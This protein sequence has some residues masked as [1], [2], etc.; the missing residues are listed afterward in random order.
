MFLQE[1]SLIILQSLFIYSFFKYPIFNEK[2]EN[3]IIKKNYITKLD[4]FV[5]NIIIFLNILIFFSIFITNIALLF[6]TYVLIILFMVANNFNQ[7]KISTGYKDLIILLITVILSIDIAYELI[8]G[9]DVQWFWFFKALNFYSDQSFL[10]LKTLPVPDYPHLG[11]YIWGFFWKF[12]F[13]NYEYLGRIAY[14][15]LYTIA[16]FSFSETLKINNQLRY[17]FSILIILATYKYNLFNGDPD[18]LIF[19]FLLF[20]AKFVYYLYTPSNKKIN[21]FLIICLLGISNILLWVKHESA[22]FIIFLIISIIIF[23]K[24][25][26]KKN[27]NILI[28]SCIFLIIIKFIILEMINYPI[29]DVEWYELDKTSSFNFNDFYYRSS[30]I[31]F[32]FFV[33]IAQNPILLIT[34][35]LMIFSIKVLKNNALNKTLL[36]FTLMTFIFIFSAY[37]FKAVEIELQI[38]H[39]M[40]EL[41]FG[42]SGFYLIIFSNIFNSYFYNNK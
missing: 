31:I 39:S 12:P 2:I 34:L 11:P 23:N 28:F 6:Y 32:Y 29:I 1:I 10:N 7:K 35:A 24:F 16:I 19:I 37:F 4:L 14:I 22:F 38:K 5:L 18:I 9:W 13:N 15:F 21:L 42:I 20:A 3:I 26:N 30:K 36:S 40:N 8:F 25:I 27:K 41:L 33:Y 17:I